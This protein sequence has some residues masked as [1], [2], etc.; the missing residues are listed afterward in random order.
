ARARRRSP[1]PGS[2]VPGEGERRRADERE[3]DAPP[4]EPDA[5]DRE[6]RRD[7]QGDLHVEA[8]RLRA[9]PRG[10]ARQPA[11]PH[12]D[13]ET[14]QREREDD[15]QRGARR[16]RDVGRRAEPP[17]GHGQQ[18]EERDLAEEGEGVDRADAVRGGPG[19]AAR[20]GVAHRAAPSSPER[21]SISP[22][23]RETS[24]KAI[25]RWRTARLYSHVTNES[26]TPSPT[27]APAMRYCSCC[28][29][30]RAHGPAR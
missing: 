13:G 3:P 18:D 15:G 4:H 30:L 2:A 11:G 20:R 8:P 27:S 24:E 19:R 17:A 9:P 12:D 28:S 23:S 22:S 26:K 7:E 29:G 5:R 16:A 14:G 1:R 10:G 25:W 6:A 21:S